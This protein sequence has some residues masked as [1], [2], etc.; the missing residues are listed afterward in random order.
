MII[1]IC[2]DLGSG[3]STVAKILASRLGFK[4]KSVGDLM[5]ELAMKKGMTLLE[6]H[7]IAQED[8][9]EIDKILDG[10]QIKLNNS[11]ENLIFDSR[12]GWHFIPNSFKIYLK[13]DI[14][15]AA[16]R[17]FNDNR[18]DEKENISLEATKEGI[19]KRKEL[20]N[21]RYKKHYN[22]DRYD[23]EKNFDIVVDT[24]NITAE[25]VAEKIL[26]KINEKNKII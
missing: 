19:I 25:E 7:K 20:E 16:R 17:I 23:D 8:G 15:E 18:E 5:G 22:L 13:V 14:D 9:G 1:T 26:K 2:G 24:T 4:R 3:K 10:E 11:K 6:F 21:Y 12:L